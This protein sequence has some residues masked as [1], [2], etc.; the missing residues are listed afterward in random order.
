MSNS[1]PVTL[2]PLFVKL[3]P[4]GCCPCPSMI[5]YTLALQWSPV[6]PFYVPHLQAST[7]LVLGTGHICASS[8]VPSSAPEKLRKDDRQFFPPQVSV[9][10]LSAQSNLSSAKAKNSRA[11]FLLFFSKNLT[12]YWDFCYLSITFKLVSRENWWTFVL[13]KISL[14]RPSSQTSLSNFF[15]SLPDQ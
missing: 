14:Y 15:H 11:I 10:S 8:A 1:W 9:N 5:A 6:L 7:S 12:I 4:P 2:P 13:Q 3:C